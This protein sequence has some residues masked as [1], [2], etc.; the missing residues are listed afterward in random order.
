MS[1]NL[2]LH[3]RIVYAGLMRMSDD[4]N[5]IKSAFN[6]WQ[7]NH[8][9][10]L[11]DVFDLVSDFVDYLGLGVAEKKGLM[12]GL[13][14]ASGKLYEDLTPVPAYIL[15]SQDGSTQQLEQA[16]SAAQATETSSAPAQTKV[17]AH[18]EVTSVYLQ[19]LSNK[20]KRAD[21]ASHRDL[22]AAVLDEGLGVMQSA[23]SAWARDDL[24]VISLSPTTSITECQDLAHQM[25][26]LV[27]DFLGPVES[28]VI[29]NQVITELS[30]IEASR[31]FNPSKLL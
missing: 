9:N 24:N 26:V 20:I 30:N 14:N 17:P 5:L 8:S 22:V 13:H 18:I 12:I 19:K 4:R 31:E 25:Y 16:T 10:K 15:A 3:Q 11:F 29:V 21:P 27:C 6:Y 7:E 28:D 1:T 23:V 2:K